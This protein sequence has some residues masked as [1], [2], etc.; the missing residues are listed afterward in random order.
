MQCGFHILSLLGGD[1]TSNI[2]VIDPLAEPGRRNA[3]DR[4]YTGWGLIEHL[5][6]DGAAKRVT[7]KM[8]LRD[9]GIVEDRDDGIS[10]FIE[11]SL[12]DCLG[13]FAVARQIECI[14][15]PGCRKRL[16]IEEPIVRIASKAVDEDGRNAVLRTSTKLVENIAAAQMSLALDDF[17]AVVVCAFDD[18][19]SN[20]GI[21][22]GITNRR[23]RQHGQQRSHRN[24]FAAFRDLAP[25]NAG[26]RT[27]EHVRDFRRFDFCYF[28]AFLNVGAL[29]D[30]PANKRALRHG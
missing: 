6:G 28:V 1:K 25:Q 7:D 9:S 11:I 8:C 18:K 14:D 5:E 3:G 15:G 12:H 2:G 17:G 22:L 26:N 23:R 13:R 21:D 20:E 16:D 10:Q 19:S 30:G 29:A 24:N 4:R 27:L